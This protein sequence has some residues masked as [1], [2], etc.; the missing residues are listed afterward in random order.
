MKYAKSIKVI[1]IFN[2]VDISEEIDSSISS[3]TYTDNSKNEIDDLELEIE[4]FDYRWLREWYPDEKAQLVVGLYENGKSYELG[5][6]YVDEP[7][8]NTNMMNLKCVALP[9]NQNIRDQ[10]N[11]KAW[12]KIT[13]EELVT[14]IATKHEMNV[15]IFTESTFFERI[16]QNFETDLG[17]IKRIISEI[18]LIMKISDDKIIIF[19]SEDLSKNESIEKFSINDPRIQSFTLKKKNKNNYDKVELSYYDPDKKKHIKEVI[20]RK[21]LEKRNNS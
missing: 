7:T 12:E 1:V 10:K 9:L 18:G 11:T 19:D 6:F 3:L 5:T 13:L 17:F 2:K 16:D 20:T 21:E 14:K 8:F 15:E 4:N